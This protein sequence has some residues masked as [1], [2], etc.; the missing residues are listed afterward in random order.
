MESNLSIVLILTVGFLLASIL[1]YAVQRLKLPT[2]LGYLLAGYIIGPYSP[3]FVA[4]LAIAEQLAE[5]GVILMLFGVG[6]H[7]KLENLISVRKIALP[8]AAMQTAVAALVSLVLVY[9]LGGSLEMGLIVGLSIGV[10]STVVLMRVLTENHLLDTVQGHIAIGWLVVEDIFTVVILILLPTIAAFSAGEK[11]VW[12][13]V[14]GSIGLVGLKLCLLA[15]LMFTWGQ[16]AV[17]YLLTKVAHKRSQELLTLS[18]LSIVFLIAVGASAI[19]GS[20]IG[21]GAFIAGMVIGKTN[22]RY[23]AASNSLPLKDMFTILFFLSVGMLFNPEAIVSYFPLFLCILFVILI[24]KPLVAYLISFLLGYP[25]KISLM[26]A[27]SLAQIGEFSFILAEEAMHLNLV[28]EEVFDLLIAAALVSISLNPILFQML[29][30]FERGIQKYSFLK[31]SQEKPLPILRRRKAAL[32][33]ILIIGFGPIGKR[34]ASIFKSFHCASSIIEENIEMVN[35]LEKQN[36]IIY[37]DG[38]DES[39]LKA[40]HIE[41]ASHLFITTFQMEKTLAIIRL[42]REINP[43]I[44]IAARVE[45]LAEKEVMEELQVE[46]VCGEEEA[47]KAFTMLI[48]HGLQKA[49]LF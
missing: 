34:I 30:R 45:S 9:L 2:I 29:D 38:A 8:G 27:V 48:Y 24:I 42:A 33:K 44:I 31:R 15:V 40:A 19:F 37:G 16:K 13:D 4:D 32:P 25:L 35:E 22:I 49:H 18:I 39:I 6:L 3:G 43:E 17:S 36:M 41:E 46:C 23:Q 14:F 5:V 21:L 26:I 28:S 47:V 20:S 10:A 11:L 12:I 1:A 7:F